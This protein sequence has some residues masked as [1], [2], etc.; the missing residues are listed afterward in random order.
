VQT[1]NVYPGRLEEVTFLGEHMEC[2]VQVA[3]ANLITRQHPSLKAEPGDTVY[4]E[5]PPGDCAVIA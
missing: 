5:L 1:A 2:R 3:G 4:V